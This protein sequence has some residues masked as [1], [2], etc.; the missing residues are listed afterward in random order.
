MTNANDDIE[1]SPA[2][3]AYA[4]NSGAREGGTQMTKPTVIPGNYDNIRARMVKLFKA[5]APCRT[6]C[7]WALDSDVPGDWPPYRE[8]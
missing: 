4:V 5:C 6:E 3:T 2:S 8:V 1:A 7:R